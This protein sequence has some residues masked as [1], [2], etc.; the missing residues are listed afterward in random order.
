ME[1]E[2]FMLNE[3]RKERMYETIHAMNVIMRALND[4]EMLEPW[5]VE[6][7]PDGTDTLEDI[8]DVYDYKEDAELYEEFERLATLFA[9]IVRDATE[10]GYEAWLY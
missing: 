5:L 8:K 9:M 10:D 2:K 1:G 4:E 3:Y 7:V 6:G